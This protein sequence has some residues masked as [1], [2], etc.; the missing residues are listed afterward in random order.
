MKKAL[1]P[2]A[3]LATVLAIVAIPVARP[4]QASAEDKQMTN[5][6]LPSF[7]GAVE[8]LNSKPLTGAELR[9]KVVL[10]EF[11]TYTCVN[12]L[13][14]LPYVRAWAKKYQDK[15]LVV[16]G[17]HTPEFGFE[18][19]LDNVRQAMKE[20]RIDYPVA[21]DSNY[22]IWNAFGNEYWPALYF[23]DAQGRI[24]HHH[25][26]EGD[27][28]QSERVIQQLL[29]EAGNN[30]VG[31]GLVSVDPKGLEAAADWSDLKSAENFLG[32][33]RTENFVSPGGV[34]ANQ[35]HVYEVPAALR[36]ND[37]ALTGAWTM[38]KEGVVLDEAGGKIAYRFH[39]R[40][41]NLIM[42]A[43]SRGASVRFRVLVDGQP[44]G[45][46]HGGDVDANGYGSVSEQRTYQLIRQPKPIVDRQFEIQ[47]LEPGVEAFDFTFG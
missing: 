3:L 15:G 14:T 32:F 18:K 13:R 31:N 17:V 43:R 42:G 28:E 5:A 35:R 21:V 22:A 1:L 45:T 8:W 23:I 2:I 47:F 20:M 39:A 24:R 36:L 41:V 11:W 37:W 6:T 16:I 38:E 29:V 44:P 34:V 10:V 9:G 7:S 26:G 25:F 40:D 30:G 33:E 4:M 46:A 19:N 12:W 27:Y